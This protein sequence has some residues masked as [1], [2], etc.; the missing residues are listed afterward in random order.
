MET[1]ER[2]AWEES[3]KRRQLEEQEKQLELQRQ[4][5]QKQEE[6]QRRMREEIIKQENA[7]RVC[8]IPCKIYVLT[9]NFL[10]RRTK[11]EDGK[12]C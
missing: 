1:E 9:Y 3:V 4:L 6:Q 10:G 11:E 2:T 7:R 8:K 12:R 5:K